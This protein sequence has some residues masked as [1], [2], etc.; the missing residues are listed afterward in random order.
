MKM[1][2]D[3]PAWSYSSLRGLASKKLLYRVVF[4]SWLFND[5]ST[6]LV[7]GN[8]NYRLSNK[9]GDRSKL[10]WD[11][12]RKASLK[13]IVEKT[14]SMLNA[15]N[16]KSKGNFIISLVLILRVSTLTICSREYAEKGG[17]CYWK[18]VD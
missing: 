11:N 3:V 10:S 16:V 2:Y 15:F 8:V 12:G 17:I 6:C 7:P 4:R 1:V 14:K 13:F 5:L 9:R 18:R